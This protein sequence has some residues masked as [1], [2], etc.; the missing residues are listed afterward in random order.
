M[1][2]RYLSAGVTGA[3]V[4]GFLILDA[5]CPVWLAVNWWAWLV[6]LPL[7][8]WCVAEWVR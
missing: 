4:V 3:A 2:R 1:L 7:G 8:F 6:F 5:A